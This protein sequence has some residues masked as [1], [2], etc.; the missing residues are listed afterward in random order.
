MGENHC[1]S[2]GFSRIMKSCFPNP[3]QESHH[4]IIKPSIRN[5]L[6]ED[7]QK[8]SSFFISVLPDDLLLE[9]LSRVP[10]SSLSSVSLVCRK[11]FGIL[12]STLYFDLRR[13]LGHI[14]RKIYAFT[15]TDYGVYAANHCISNEE[16]DESQGEGG[17]DSSS[18]AGWSLSS[19]FSAAGMLTQGSFSHSRVI[20][21]GK[22]IYIVNRD[23]TL[24]YDVWMGVITVK[25]PMLYPRKKFAMAN[26]NGKI[27]ISGGAARNEVVEEYEPETDTWRVVSEAP[28]RRYG[29]IGAAVD[30]VF[31]VI[32]GLKIGGGGGNGKNEAMMRGGCSEA[33]LYASSMDL[34]DVQS[35]V[36]MRSRTVPGGGCVVAACAAGGY[37]YILASHAVELSFWRFD[38]RRKRNGG[39]GG[40]GEWCRMKSPPLPAQVR[41]DS[42]VR[43]SC[44][45]IGG[46]NYSSGNDNKVV[47]VQVLGCI[48]DLL[49]RSGRS[50]RGMKEGLVLVYDGNVEEWSRGVDLPEVIRRASC[51]SVEC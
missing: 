41:L 40:F 14:R 30:G 34:F 10:S 31:Y 47:L 33:H 19:P 32:G 13:S 12:N 24:G 8:S 48:D 9:C 23:V 29:C 17:A 27:Y 20:S 38:G 36:W 25:S 16:S 3:Q 28:R 42:S 50:C 46:E 37:V 7:D 44:V 51:V 35:R 45:G 6:L 2:R 43:F 11:W 21:V 18:S 49:R 5:R 39:G 4:L 22:V 26:V 15:V 1:N